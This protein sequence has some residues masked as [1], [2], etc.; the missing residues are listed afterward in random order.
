MALKAGYK[1]I[2]KSVLDSLLTL[3]GSVVI[4]EIGDG[5]T[6][7]TDGELS[8]DINDVGDGL[9][10]SESG[11]ASVDIDSNTME[12]T[13]DGKLKSKVTSGYTQDIL[14]GNDTITYPPTKPST[15]DLSHAYDDYDMLIVVS[16]FTSTGVS[17][18]QLWTLPTSE[19]AQA[20]VDPTADND[21]IIPL[22]CNAG[23]SS[24]GQWIRVGN[25]GSTKEALSFRYN[26]DVGVYKIIGVKF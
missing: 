4:K 6:L 12:F 15:V 5:L 24:G 20:S 21:K 9:T 10:L 8:A 16:G 14:W 18:Y 3:L 1:G 17:C 19:L 11:T 2:K 25:H 22:P 7:D 13:E 23:D 26:G